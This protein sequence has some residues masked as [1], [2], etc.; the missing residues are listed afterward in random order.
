MADIYIEKVNEA[1]I[2]IHADL[3]YRK[4]L[5]EYF[6]F[7]AKNYIYDRRYLNGWWSGDIHIMDAK[8]STL[9]LGILGKVQ[10]FARARGYTL[11]LDPKLTPEPLEFTAAM[12]RRFIESLDIHHDGLPIAPRDHQIEALVKAVRD[13]R[14][15][16]LLSTGSGKTYIDYVLIRW[17]L[18]LGLKGLIVVP[19]TGLCTQLRA[20]FVD[21]SSHNG[22]DVDAHLHMVYSGQERDSPKPV[23]V[24]TWQSAVKREDSYLESFEFLIG[25]EADTFKAKSLISIGTRMTR[26]EHRIGMTGSLDDSQVDALV[27]EGLFGPI[28]RLTTTKELMDK[29]EL[30]KIKILCPIL[31]HTP[32][33][34]KALRKQNA[35]DA[36]EMKERGKDAPQKFYKN[37][38]DYLV[39]CV[40]RTAFVRNLAVSLEGTTVVLFQYLEHGKVLYEQI[41]AAAGSRKVF[42]VAGEVTPVL[43]E[44][45]RLELNAN[46]G[47]IVVASF[48]TFARG[49]NIPNIMHIVFAFVFKAKA[50]LLQSIGRGLRVFVDKGWITLYDIVDDMRTKSWDNYSIRHFQERL[51]TYGEEGFP[52]KMFNIDLPA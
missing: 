4:E 26:A 12:A 44:Q 45:I 9:Y 6:T 15:F 21:Y 36:K 1:Y 47:S 41:K 5:W 11:E 29:G 25:E 27:L 39:G 46:P 38:V 8:K 7:K 31:R 33:A 23:V 10:E 32:E 16:Y 20:D 3:G 2:K 18:A 13:R 50:K 51:E 49:I 30:S 17:Y 43:R 40:S 35:D 14:G 28:Q 19:T 42:Y 34:I 48:G 52:Y 24:S 22:W 37:E